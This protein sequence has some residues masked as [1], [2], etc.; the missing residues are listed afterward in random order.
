MKE[1][2]TIYV[3]NDENKYLQC[4]LKK[5]NVPFLRNQVWK[6]FHGDVI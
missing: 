6:N 1:C 3:I 5:Y 2:M 4:S